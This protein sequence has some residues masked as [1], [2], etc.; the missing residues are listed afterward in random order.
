[1]K[2]TKNGI[3]IEYF[4]EGNE[5]LSVYADV[6]E[7]LDKSETFTIKTDVQDKSVNV[8]VNQAGRREIFTDDW[9]LADGTTFN[10]IKKN[11]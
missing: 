5:T 6:N 11:V 3:T 2:A 1:M 10:V 4:G 7:S 8:I 9:R